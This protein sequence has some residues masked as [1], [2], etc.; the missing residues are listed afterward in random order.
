MCS[1]IQ[2]CVVTIINVLFFYI[3]NHTGFGHLH[4]TAS[5]RLVQ[6]HSPSSRSKYQSQFWSFILSC[7]S[8]QLN[9]AAI[10]SPHT[11]AFIEY[12]AQKRLVSCIYRHLHVCPQ[13]LLLR[14]VNP[15]T[16][17]RLFQVRG[18]CGFL[19]RGALAPHPGP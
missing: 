11:V 3:H 18:V 14:L 1:I 4:A 6:A 19:F 9:M 13:A 10:Q 15:L 17:S 7:S 8:Y 12:L 16:R 5:P 2:E